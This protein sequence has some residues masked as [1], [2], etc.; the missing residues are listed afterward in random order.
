MFGIQ[1]ENLPVGHVEALQSI[2]AQDL[3]E[4]L[5][6]KQEVAGLKCPYEKGFLARWPIMRTN[7]E[8]TGRKMAIQLVLFSK[9]SRIVVFFVE[10]SAYHRTSLPDTARLLFLLLLCFGSIF[11][12]LILVEILFGYVK[13]VVFPRRIS[14]INAVY[15]VIS[16][17]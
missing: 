9:C 15:D 6:R 14:L 1:P 10:N 11:T 7:H 17:E 3:Y 16:L 12:W 5:R 4:F 8:K 2:P 13:T